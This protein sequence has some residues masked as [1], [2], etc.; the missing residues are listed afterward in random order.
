M[1]ELKSYTR[2][3]IVKAFEVQIMIPQKTLNTEENIRKYNDALWEDIE[4]IVMRRQIAKYN[5][6]TSSAER[7]KIY[8]K[9]RDM[10]EEIEKENQRKTA[11][12]SIRSKK[13][14][15]FRYWVGDRGQRFCG[16]IRGREKRQKRLLAGLC[17]HI[18]Y[19]LYGKMVIFQMKSES[20]M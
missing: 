3:F 9:Y 2:E 6:P 11:S 20:S 4:V 13:Q 7:E 14:L 18:L 16:N 8:N 17:I 5:M 10:K 15:A 1:D 19:L 12:N